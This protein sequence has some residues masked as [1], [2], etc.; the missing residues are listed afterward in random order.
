MKL[1]RGLIS[2]LKHALQNS[3]ISI[4]CPQRVSIVD[5]QVLMQTIMGLDQEKGPFCFSYKSIFSESSPLC[6]QCYP[7]LTQGPYPRVFR[8]CLIRRA[9]SLFLKVYTV[10]MQITNEIQHHMQKKGVPNI[11]FLLTVRC[12]DKPFSS[13]LHALIKLLILR[14]FF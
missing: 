6:A 12:F 2:K 7:L 3:D 4:G 13:V 9:L 14:L 10:I 5:R 1:D 8:N 11:C